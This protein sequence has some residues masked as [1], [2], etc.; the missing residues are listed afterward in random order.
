MQAW[1]IKGASSGKIQS[2]LQQSVICA[3]PD[4][5][6]GRSFKP[7]IPFLI[8]LLSFVTLFSSAQ[9][10]KDFYIQGNNNR[11]AAEWEPALGTMIVWPLCLPSKLVIELAKDDHLYTLVVNDSAKKEAQQWFGKWGIDPARTTF[12]Y[13]LQGIDAWWVRDWGPSAVFSPSGKMAFG[14]GKYIYSTPVTNIGCNDSLEFLYKT[15]DKKIIKTETDDNATIPFGKGMNTDVLDLPFANTGGNV[16]TDGLGTAF[17]TCILINENKFYGV[18]KD[19]FI[20][21]NKNLLGIS[22]YNIISNFEKK[23]IQHIDCY[24]KLLDEERILVCEP[25]ADHNHYTIYQNIIDNELSKLKTP[26]G[27][28]YEIL[29]I[30]S[31]R[32]AGQALAAYTNAI[33]INKNIYVPLF[34]IP[35]DNEALQRWKEVMPGY[36]VKGFEFTIAAEPYDT[37]HLKGHYPAYGWNDG[38]ALHCR[39]RAIWDPNMLFISAKRVDKEVDPQHKN[40]VYIT[41]IDYSNKGLLKGY[42][43]LAWRVAGS[44]NW[45]HVALKTSGNENNFFAEIPYHKPGATIEYYISAAS[46]SGRKE[47]MPKTAPIGLYKFSIK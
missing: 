21:L 45:S 31:A 40:I 9:T 3:R 8:T 27:R 35:Q 25:P 16:L 6:A 2:A 24:M 28:P 44:P 19:Q 4:G 13:A 30:K 14:D 47:T 1:Y 12:I 38:D 43:E 39:T 42:A 29:R 17:S 26:Y 10:D 15:A 22:T 20:D 7:V 36:T 11:V 5:P 18:S 37:K 46:M 32:Y 34:H 33:I 23:G 41:I